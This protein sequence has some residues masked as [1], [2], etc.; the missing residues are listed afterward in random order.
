MSP[1]PLLA[2]KYLDSLPVPIHPWP[3]KTAPYTLGVPNAPDAP[4]TP[5]G[6]EYLQFLPV[7]QYTSDTPCTPCQPYNGPQ[8]PY[9]P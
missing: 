8:H 1:I 3:P 4:Y 2:P 7:H 6:P 5:S 9:T